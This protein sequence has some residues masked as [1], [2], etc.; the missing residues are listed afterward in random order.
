MEEERKKAE[1]EIKPPSYLLTTESVAHKMDNSINKSQLN[2]FLK[3]SQSEA[4]HEMMM[5]LGKDRIREFRNIGKSI[6]KMKEIHATML[7]SYKDPEPSSPPISQLTVS[8][9][10]SNQNLRNSQNS[11]M[12]MSFNRGLESRNSVL[13]ERSASYLEQKVV[14][15]AR[16][17]PEFTSTADEK[18]LRQMHS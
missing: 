6:E 5:K 16:N 17:T 3:K 12:R 2:R 1:E 13:S 9:Q 4:S 11:F 10:V 14:E 7:K 8:P 15:K 18:I